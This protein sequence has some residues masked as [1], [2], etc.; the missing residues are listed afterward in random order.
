MAGESQSLPVRDTE[1]PSCPRR[2]GLVIGRSPPPQTPRCR[3]AGRG[4]SPEHRGS[5]PISNRMPSPRE[6]RY[7]RFSVRS[8]H[9]RDDEDSLPA[10]NECNMA[11]VWGPR[12]IV[13]GPGTVGQLP[14]RFCV[15][16]LNVNVLDGRLCGS[17]PA[18]CYELAVRR[19]A[20]RYFRA[21]I[22]CQR[23]RHG[24]RRRRIAPEEPDRGANCPDQA[25]RSRHQ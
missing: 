9:W 20:G 13:L 12:R 1:T 6:C 10:S 4:A 22:N 16:V 23:H 8:P 19:E 15:Y 2:R 11:A 14:Q 17:G 24:R 21:G 5:V 3:T 25:D 7:R 18:K